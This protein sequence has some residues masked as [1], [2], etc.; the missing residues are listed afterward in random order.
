MGNARATEK[1]SFFI[2]GLLFVSNRVYC[3]RCSDSRRT[4]VGFQRDGFIDGE[5]LI[6]I[7]AVD[8]NRTAANRVVCLP[9][10]QE[11][12]VQGAKLEQWKWGIPPRPI[13][14]C[15]HPNLHPVPAGEVQKW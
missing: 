10:S 12:K 6:V 15:G 1:G 5:T 2:T 13:I 8:V 9:H 7:A 3:S 14:V 11:G 4:L